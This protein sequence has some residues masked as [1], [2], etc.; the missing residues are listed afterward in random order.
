MTEWQIREARLLKEPVTGIGQERGR[1]I[2][3]K[4]FEPQQEKPKQ[5]V[6][7]GIPQERG[8]QIYGKCFVPPPKEPR[9]EVVKGIPIER[10]NKIY[11]KSFVSPPVVKG[12]PIE[13][14]NKI[15]GKSFVPPPKEPRQEPVTESDEQLTMVPEL[16]KKKTLNRQA[17]SSIAGR[18]QQGVRELKQN[19]VIDHKTKV[20]GVGTF[21]R[22]FLSNNIHDKEHQVAIKVLDKHKLKDE[23][24]CIIEEVAILNKLDHPNIVKYFETYD[25]TKYIYLVMEYIKGQ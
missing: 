23:I 7:V 8:R 18:I 20:L 6:A 22:I 9:Q 19:Y 17:I 12:I 5:E 1:K 11:G 3:G 10:G 2:Y 15:F 24:D 25:D 14:G 4:S 21:G 13:R 16:Q